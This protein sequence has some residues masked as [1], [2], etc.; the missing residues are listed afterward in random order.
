MT[1]PSRNTVGTVI[2]TVGITL[3]VVG[4]VSLTKPEPLSH[5]QI[6]Y[7]GF[8]VEVSPTSCYTIVPND[9]YSFPGVDPADPAGDWMIVPC[10]S[11]Q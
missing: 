10:E 7:R 3:S 8:V 9:A 4:L 1:R 6:T 2:A 11:L 5:P